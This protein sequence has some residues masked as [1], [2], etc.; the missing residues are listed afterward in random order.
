MGNISLAA[1]STIALAFGS[2][3]VVLAADLK[4]PI[5]KAPPSPVVAVYSW[6]GFYIGGHI[7]GAWS[8]GSEATVSRLP[9]AAAGG[10]PTFTLDADD[11][12]WIGGGQIGFNWQFARNW[13]AGV[14][15]DFSFA[16]ISGGSRISPV[17]RLDP[18]T[19][20]PFSFASASHDLDWLGSV[21][22]RLGYAWD[23]WLLYATGGL[24]YGRSKYAA[25]VD[26][27]DIVFPVAFA[28]TK[29]G[30]TVGGGMEYGAWGAWTIRAEYLYYDLNAASGS[31]SGIPS[32]A[33][34]GFRYDWD[35]KVH[36][37]RFGLNY[38][39]GAAPV[40]A[41]Y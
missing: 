9:N 37:A 7:G 12:S 19:I 33:P 2:T 22:A 31:S 39:F 24:A 17:P 25:T 27:T 14:E 36:V 13:V 4:A 34:R 16:G 29:T 15:A 18:S 1:L 6:T 11:S 28:A 41:R 26:L 30:W 23:R 21:R 5:G 20:N 10:F 38:R 8:S 40:V 3:S 35:T 32:D